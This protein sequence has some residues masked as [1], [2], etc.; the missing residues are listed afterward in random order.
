MKGNLDVDA[1]VQDLR[2]HFG[3]GARHFSMMNVALGQIDTFVQTEN[4]EGL[5][6]L[7]QNAGLNIMNY[8]DI[9]EED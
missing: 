8:I 6:Q 2:D 1:L 9:T 4:W 3:T 7:A 5:I